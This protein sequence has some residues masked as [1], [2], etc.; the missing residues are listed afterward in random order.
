MSSVGVKD[1]RKYE[2]RVM[3]PV[4]STQV[5]LVNSCTKTYHL[6]QSGTHKGYEMLAFSSRL[7]VGP[8]LVRVG[9]LIAVHITKRDSDNSQRDSLFHKYN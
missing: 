2:R 8:S 9:V 4:D 1:I 3:I 7:N 5:S 6:S